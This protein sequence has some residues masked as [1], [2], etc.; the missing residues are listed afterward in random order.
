MQLR[1]YI[2]LTGNRMYVPSTDKNRPGLL[3]S[4]SVAHVCNS[5]SVLAVGISTKEHSTTLIGI[6]IAFPAGMLHVRSAP[7]LVLNA[8]TQEAY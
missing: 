8:R 5:S 4:F 3:D 1:K 7:P 2:I 6:R